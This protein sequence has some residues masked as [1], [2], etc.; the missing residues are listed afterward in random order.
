MGN[1]IKIITNK[2]RL[3]EKKWIF[4]TIFN[5]HANV[6]YNLELSEE[7]SGV[8]FLH[9]NKKVHVEDHFFEKY[10]ENWLSYDSLPKSPLEK[11][12][13]NKISK[14][15]IIPGNS[16]PVI[17]GEANVIQEDEIITFKLDIIG[18]I[19]FMLSRYEEIVLHY[20]DSHDR[21]SAF[22]S[23][24]YKQG[25]LEKPIADHY[26]QLFFYYLNIKVS[27]TENSPNICFTCDVD[28]LFEYYVKNNRIFTK[29]LLKNLF[30]LNLKELFLLTRNYVFVN[31][32]KDYRFDKSYTFEWMMDL[33]EEND[34]KMI[35]FILANQDKPY[36][37]DYSI[38]SNELKYLL[39]EIDRRG[40]IIGLHGSY[41]TYRNANLLKKELTNLQ[42]QLN[43]WNIHQKVEKIRQHYLRYDSSLTQYIM[44]QV[45]LKEDYTGGYADH[46]GFRYGT[47][48]SFRVW[49]WQTNS[50]LKLKESPLIF[51]EVTMFSE[52][53]MNGDYD[54]ISLDIIKKLMS[55]STN[56]NLLWHNSFLKD[57]RQKTFLI[58][59]L[60]SR[61]GTTAN[62]KKGKW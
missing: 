17:Y 61:S 59:I 23:L 6:Q 30:K 44:E 12:Y 41:H 57:T 20:R 35:F 37:P 29:L 52:K 8:L 31:L 51:M 34:L 18:S 21:F 11:F 42:S 49:D 45:G 22:D 1:I 40:H 9:K 60:N 43:K 13:L 24:A 2:I 54:N 33:A 25:F 38:K 7:V 10:K 47:S 3:T 16:I 55:Q 62:L 36:N 46:I 15:L 28:T 14:K 4:D 56:F 58:S 48:L 27:K 39:K 50:V 19:F 5:I 32:L 26:I 53:Y